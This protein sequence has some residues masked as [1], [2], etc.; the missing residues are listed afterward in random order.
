VVRGTKSVS[1]MEGLH[2][3][4]FHRQYF[5]KLLIDKGNFSTPYKSNNAGVSLSI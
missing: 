1:Q 4:G 3:D 5:I 2:E